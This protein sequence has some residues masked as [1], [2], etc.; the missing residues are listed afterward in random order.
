MTVNLFQSA[1]EGDFQSIRQAIEEGS[2]SLEKVD[3]ED[4]RTL[5]HWAC[6]GKH[7]HIVEYLLSVL[8]F[9]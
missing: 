6:S 8:P 7:G 9:V 5:L 1:F 3:P 2:F 4:E